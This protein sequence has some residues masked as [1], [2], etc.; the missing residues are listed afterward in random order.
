MHTEGRSDDVKHMKYRGGGKDLV[1]KDKTSPLDDLYFWSYFQLEYFLNLSEKHR[2]WRGDMLKGRERSRGGRFVS[3]SEIFIQHSCLLSS[4]Y[5]VDGLCTHKDK[6]KTRVPRG[7]LSLTVSVNTHP[8]GTELG[9]VERSRW[10]GK[11]WR[12]SSNWGQAKDECSQPSLQK[13]S[14]EKLSR[15]GATAEDGWCRFRERL[16]QIS[17]HQVW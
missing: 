9:E 8:K 2:C 5:W 4:T 14:T 6:Q 12:D 11:G 7:G 16:P 1:E 17:N 15:G 3:G 10:M 13:S